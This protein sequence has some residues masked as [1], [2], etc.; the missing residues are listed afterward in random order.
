MNKKDQELLAKILMETIYE[1]MGDGGDYSDDNYSPS[2]EELREQL[3]N[4]KEE[5]YNLRRQMKRIESDLSDKYELI[6]SIIAQF[7][8]LY[9][10]SDIDY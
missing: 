9:P 10:D 1:P 3:D 5:V 2:E 6:D 7:N 8:D 4:T